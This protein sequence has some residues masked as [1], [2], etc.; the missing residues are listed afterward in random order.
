M[1]GRQHPTKIY[2]LLGF[3]TDDEIEKIKLHKKALENFRKNNIL[4]AIDEYKKVWDIPS[5]KFTM[6]LQ[7]LRKIE[8]YQKALLEYRKKD[9]KKA[10]KLFDE[11]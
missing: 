4:K 10:K 5:E 8:L 7:D 1:K 3:N 9:F 11:I 6:K 2:E